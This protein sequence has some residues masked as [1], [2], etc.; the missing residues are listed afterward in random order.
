[1]KID[2]RNSTLKL[3]VEGNDDQ[4]VI[5]AICEKYKIAETFDVIDNGSINRV[6]KR[7]PVDLKDD[8]IQTVGVIVDADQNMQASLAKPE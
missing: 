5:W 4:H 8:S 1:M 2:K 7:L 3:L 6:L